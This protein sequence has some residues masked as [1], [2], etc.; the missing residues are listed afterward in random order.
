MK[1]ILLSSLPVITAVL[2][3]FII[4]L[5]VTALDSVQAQIDKAT[6][7]IFLNKNKNLLPT[8]NND[9][10]NEHEYQYNGEKRVMT[11]S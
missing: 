4:T 6:T 3:L 7:I 9:Y 8:A 2:I 1:K 11:H 10:D 5:G